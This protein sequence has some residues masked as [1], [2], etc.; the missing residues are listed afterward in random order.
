VRGKTLLRVRLGGMFTLRRGCGSGVGGVRLTIDELPKPLF[1]GEVFLSGGRGEWTSET[2]YD[3]E[4]SSSRTLAT[5]NANV[6]I[7]DDV[8]MQLGGG[9]SCFYELFLEADDLLVSLKLKVVKGG[10]EERV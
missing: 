1:V 4:D 7:L 2:P 5:V 6:F 8:T 10:F 3:G 9:Y